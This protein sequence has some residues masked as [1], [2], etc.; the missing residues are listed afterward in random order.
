LPNEHF[1]ERTFY[2]TDSLPNRQFAE[3]RDNLLNFIGSL[4][5]S[6]FL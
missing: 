4:T 6:N 5:R 3:N 1:A 2:R